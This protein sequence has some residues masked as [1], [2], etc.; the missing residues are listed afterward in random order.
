MSTR[1]GGGTTDLDSSGK[2]SISVKAFDPL[3]GCRENPGFGAAE[4]S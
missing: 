1:L 4:G 2:K 3:F